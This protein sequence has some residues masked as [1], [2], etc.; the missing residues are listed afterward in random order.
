MILMT[1]LGLT[2]VVSVNSDMMINGYYGNSRAAYYAA[3]SGIN[4][5]R[6]YLSNQLQSQVYMGACLGWGANAFTPDCVSAPLNAATAPAA[7]LANLQA[8]YQA[9]TPL[10]SGNAVHSWPSSFMIQN[11]ATCTSSIQ[12]APGSPVITPSGPN[13]ID[14]RTLNIDYKYTF[15]YVLCSTGRGAALQRSAVKEVGV[16]L[17]DVKSLDLPAPTFAGYGQFVDHQASCP[18]A[19]LTPGTYTGPTF[20]NGTWALGNIG[21]YIFT[22]PVLQVQPKIDYYV[23]SN[24]TPSTSSTFPGITATFQQGLV[25][26]ANAITPPANSYS[27]KYAVID[28]YGATTYT[29]AQ[30]GQY[31]KDVNGNAYSGG[32][33]VYL[34]YSGSN[35]G[36]VGGIG[37]GIYVEG[38]ASIL[39]T[40]GTDSATP[41]NPTQIYTITQ[42]SGTCPGSNCT[43]TTVTINSKTKQTTMVSAGKVTGNTGQLTGVPQNPANPL[44]PS[45]ATPTMLY[46][47]G[48][49]TG[50]T[51]P[52]EGQ[53]AIQN[54]FMVSI[55][56]SNNISITGDLKYATE[57][58]T[59]NTADTLLL[60]QT[61]TQNSTCTNCFQTL[62]V[63]TANGTINLNSPYADHNIETDG[64]LAAIGSG[65]PNNSCG[66]TNT[67]NINTWTNVGGQIQSNQFVCTIQTANTFYDQRFTQWANIGFA[68]PWF[69]STSTTGNYTPGTPT[70]TPT[71]QRTSWA[72]VSAQ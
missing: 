48:S 50:L 5:A 47:D 36:G 42:G 15:N 63:F 60:P 23:G 70:K 58:V 41:P 25:L 71:Q 43:V 45:V 46:V 68:P 4:I 19:F 17:L 40:P 64:A 51:G 69:P 67:G 52:A 55:A 35:Y 65:C 16:L 39:L 6:Q 24:C 3:D 26:G 49:I 31:L 30:M 14:G 22:N 44:I 61:E 62:G 10:N 59:L 2:M 72:W 28:G 66:F 53:A 7:A 12:N 9:L 32:T 33:G 34:P 18:G 37:G 21:P 1:I 11:S 13:A 29:T 27:Q 20:T 56:S 54:N 38:N 8:A 57:P